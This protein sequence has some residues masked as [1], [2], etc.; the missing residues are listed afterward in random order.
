VRP[1]NGV[2]KSIGKAACALALL[3]AGLSV[4]GCS[5]QESATA[6]GVATSKV[7]ERDFHISAPKHLPPGDVHLVVRNRGPVAH[8]LIVV[9]SDGH[10]LPLRVDG[11]TVDE[12]AV[13]DR[14]AVALEPGEPGVR[15]VDLSLEP[16]RYVMFCN[17]SGHFM[18]GMYA[19][20][21]VG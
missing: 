9:R 6:A 4:G 1:D 10:P 12:D 14:T 19:D 18:G 11:L 20:L 3:A 17:M 5:A 21:D 16:G 13:E 2:V 15:T 8:E 7:V